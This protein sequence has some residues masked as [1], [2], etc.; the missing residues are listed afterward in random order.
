MDG[1]A[2]WRHLKVLRPQRKVRFV[3]SWAE[4]LRLRSVEQEPLPWSDVG[5]L[6]VV[7]IPEER[8]SRVRYG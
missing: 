7:P 1:A 8:A 3:F 5:N 6:L 4:T 2:A